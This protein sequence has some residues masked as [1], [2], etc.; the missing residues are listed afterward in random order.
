MNEVARQ[1][2]LFTVDQ[3]IEQHAQNVERVQRDAIFEIG[4]ELAGAQDKFRYS[5]IEGG[6]TGWLE[7]RLPHIT[8][9][10]A[11]RLIAIFKNVDPRM[12][13]D[14]TN[15]SEFALSEVAKIEPDIQALIAERV[16]AGDIFTAEAVKQLREEAAREAVKA[17]TD[18]AKELRSKLAALQKDQKAGANK[19]EEIAALK[20]QLEEIQ[21]DPVMR[22]MRKAVESAAAKP[23]DKRSNKNPAYQ[24]DP[25][26][27]ETLKVVGPCR[28]LAARSKN[29]NVALVVRGFI[30]D[31]DR[32][33]GLQAIRDCRDF[34]NLV[35]EEAKNV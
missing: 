24:P 32:E 21:N 22:E 16:A 4:R 33:A 27:D 11:Y 26:F 2:D 25:A 31:G 10:T 23:A 5:R 12:F 20:A 18:E 9:T 13:V 7:R 30:D 19:D 34:L 17:M 14:S 3:Q 35:L 8:E 1:P 6:F 29:I 15:I 28:A